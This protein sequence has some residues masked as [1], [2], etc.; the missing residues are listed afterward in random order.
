MT[1]PT[2][3]TPPS[4]SIDLRKTV[5]THWTSAEARDWVTFESTL[6]EDVVYE[7]PQTRERIRGKEAFLQFYREYPG[8]WHL[9]VE[10]IVAEG[11]Q[12][13]TWIHAA[14]GLEEMY[15]LTFFTGDEEGR[16]TTITDFWP[17]AY[18]PPPGREHLVERY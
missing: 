4:S 1:S 11:G 15:A 6:A 16:I 17:E 14:V 3:S 2:E 12:V 13:V 10:R 5:E 8:D 18:E 7:L 9:R